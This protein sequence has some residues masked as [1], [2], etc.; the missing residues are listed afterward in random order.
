MV[1]CTELESI[2]Q[3]RE[4][5]ERIQHQASQT[6]NSGHYYIG[7]DGQ[8][9]EFVSPTYVAHHVIGQNDYSIGIELDNRGRYPTWFDSDA[10]T[11]T[12]KY[13]PE[14]VQ[15]LIALLQHLM[16]LYPS[17]RLLAG[18][19]DLDDTWIPAEN[20]PAI[21]IKRKIDP[22]PLFPW[23]TIEQQVPLTW[24]IFTAADGT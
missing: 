22:G 7:K 10:Q 16:A 5:G 14:Q 8:V 11:V 3:A 15:S 21:T 19:E 23:S 24:L 20:D 12:D 2:E 18:H 13:P 1:H 4:F 9:Y 6:G 17:L